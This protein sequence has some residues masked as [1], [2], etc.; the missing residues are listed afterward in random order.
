MPANEAPEAKSLKVG[1][2]IT[3]TF[4]TLA[5]IVNSLHRSTGRTVLEIDSDLSKPS[6]ERRKSIGESIFG[7]R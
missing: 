1:E 3:G 5:F 2:A 6:T 7:L 4:D